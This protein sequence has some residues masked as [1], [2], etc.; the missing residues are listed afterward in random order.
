MNKHVKTSNFDTDSDHDIVVTTLKTKGNVRHEETVIR[1]DYSKF[2]K[3]L[4]LLD[5]MGIKWSEVYDIK[6]PVIINSLITENIWEKMIIRSFG[7]IG[8]SQEEEDIW[9]CE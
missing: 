9:L 7:S 4:Y 8:W 3:E 5:L 6:D 1:R 2:N